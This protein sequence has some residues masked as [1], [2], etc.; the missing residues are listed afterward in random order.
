MKTFLTVDVLCEVLKHQSAADQKSL[1]SV[2]R[3]AAHA[4]EHGIQLGVINRSIGTFGNPKTQKED[5]RAR[6][7][8]F[9]HKHV[10]RCGEWDIHL[11]GSTPTHILRLSVQEPEPWTV[12]FGRARNL[13]QVTTVKDIY[14]FPEGATLGTLKLSGVPELKL[15]CEYSLAL[16]DVPKRVVL[17][18]LPGLE[19]ISAMVL[20]GCK[21][22]CFV[23]L[24]N[25]PLLRTIG[26]GFATGSSIETIDLSGL[27][28]LT[29]LGDSFLE[30]CECIRNFRLS[31]LPALSSIGDAL[32]AECPLLVEV[33]LEYLPSL[34]R[35]GDGALQNCPQLAQ[36]TLRALPKLQT[37]L[38]IPGAK[39]QQH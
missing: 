1:R 26:S 37:H 34:E 27:P 25:L 8:P 15:L 35:I 18:D 33:V 19:E 5:K 7:F 23:Q 21:R 6:W 16:D 4:F 30:K 36:V 11:E 22:L 2:C 39:L 9:P 32:L 13:K 12:L 24:K 20:E 38:R 17:E 29:E 3:N 10:W 28:A 31:N 14:Y